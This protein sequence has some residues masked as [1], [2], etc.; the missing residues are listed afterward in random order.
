MTFQIMNRESGVIYTVLGMGREIESTSDHV[1]YIG[2]D[3]RLWVRNVDQFY[4]GKFVRLVRAPEVPHKPVPMRAYAYK[5]F[6]EWMPQIQWE[7]WMEGE[8]HHHYP[9]PPQPGYWRDG[10]IYQY[11]LIEGRPVL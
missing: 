2:R 3:G 11:T 5:L 6:G 1:L 10:C 9:A 8:V 4:G 7:P